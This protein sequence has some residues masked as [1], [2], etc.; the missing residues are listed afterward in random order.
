MKF[1]LSWLLDHLQTSADLTRIT[2]TLSAIGLE[3]ESVE[4]RGPALAPF[5]IAR[6]RDAAPHPN[7]DRLQVCTVELG[8][9]KT[10]TVVCGAPNARA[11][12]PVV[13]APPGTFIPASGITLKVGEIRGVQSEGM[14]V[15]E[16][17]LGL[18]E[19]HNGIIELEDDA[20]I[21]T[22]FAAWA[23]LDDPVVEI[24]ITPNRGDALS[25]RGIARDLAAAGLGALK[26][27]APPPIA[28]KFCTIGWKI[29]SKEAC[30]WV[31]G[32]T[33]HNVSNPPSP[34]W[35][36]RRLIAIGLRPINALV[37]IT[38][39][40]TY[41]IGRPL[42]AYD[43]DQIVGGTLK[44]RGGD[45][46][47]ETFTALGGRKIAI[48]E[49]DLVVADAEK[50][51]GLAGV[52]G[53]EDSGCTEATT[54]VF[55]EC[56]LF[57]PIQIGQTGR[58]HQVNTD[59]RARFERGLDQALL[60]RALDAATHM[61]VQICGGEPSEITS[62]GAEPRWR[63]QASLR[64]DRLKTLGGSDITPDQA[65]KILADLGFEAGTRDE[66]QVTVTVPSWRNDV[67]HSSAPDQAGVI[68]SAIAEKAA[69]GA[70]EIEPEVDLIEEV[71]RIAGIDNVPPVSLPPIS[72]VPGAAINFGQKTASIARRALATRGFAECVSFTFM[73]AHDAARFGTIDDAMRVQNPIA[74]DLDC[75]RPTPLAS[76]ALAA[77]RNAA[78][79]YGQVALF[80][81]GPGFN[82]YG[83]TP[84]ASGLRAGSAPR[85]WQGSTE[86]PDA[87]AAKADLFA[88]LATLGVPMDALSVTADAPAY[89]HPGQS[90]VVRQGPKTVLGRFGML[91]PEL[92]EA[93]GIDGDVCAFEL[94]LDAINEPKRR[95]RAPA[96]LPALQPITRDFAFVVDGATPADAVLRAARGADRALITAVTLFDVYTGE[97]VP[98]GQKSLGVEV[99]LQPRERTLTDED[100]DAAC[101]RIIDSVTRATGATLR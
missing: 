59:A 33:I 25:I 97:N 38:N 92:A 43:A 11:G 50:V 10:A 61:I 85:H 24:A 45:P 79:G 90:G 21:G 52:I 57:D 13:F 2:D 20:P 66:H 30:P 8:G 54:N 6:I 84:M 99:T 74:A 63:R 70:A 56:A 87:F 71:L 82:A 78:R 96:D 49:D 4:N 46:M 81:V 27:W 17:E 3:V 55:L 12:L 100:I 41:D 93:I 23:G 5:L 26:P 101:T 32:R 42:H 62:A 7:A 80:E 15:S 9:D 39:Y 51:L 65:C 89:Y 72:A 67:A 22:P 28:G 16:R 75:L 73:A 48:A 37:D 34:A 40:F 91:H 77:A 76:I 53:G 60:A 58:R 47:G 29:V 1:S 18:G 88:L 14:L 86:S 19:D 44:L 69:I 83:Q 36:Q 68:D 64:F 95:R 31:V 94:F 98:D 35:L